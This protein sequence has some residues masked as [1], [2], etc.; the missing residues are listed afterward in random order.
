[1]EFS[2]SL[3]RG[4]LYRLFLFLVCCEIAF[5]ALYAVDQLLGSPIWTI[6]RLVDLDHEQNI[7]TWFSVIQLF[8]I[9]LLITLKAFRR[10]PGRDPS[11]PLLL[12]A[13][14]AFVFL[15]L[16]EAASIHES[17]T[18]AL[19]HIEQLPRFEGDH[20]MWIPIYGGLI[21]LALAIGLPGIRLMWA[22]HRAALLVA[23]GGAGVFVFG[24]VGLE[25]ISYQY[26]TPGT[27][28]YALEV[29]VEEFL[30]MLGA[31]LMLYGSVLFNMD[32]APAVE[33]IDIDEPALARAA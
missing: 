13:A 28:M 12:L 2:F 3:T 5:V 10:Q 6:Q 7:P 31:S 25:I 4:Q 21:L 9:G 16:D 20:G 23:G 1:M 17:V 32:A 26:L 18:Q 15:S 29:G 8:F 24:A 19:L 27:P 33:A 11:R 30:E 22:H 14:G